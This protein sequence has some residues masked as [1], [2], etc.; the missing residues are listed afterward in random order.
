[1]NLAAHLSRIARS[2]PDAPAIGDGTDHLTY[3]ELDE[4]VTRLA[5][6]FHAAGLKRGD[7][8]AIAM[9]NRPEL[10]E[11]ILACFRAALVAVP[12]N[13]RLHASEIEYIVAHADARI[14][15]AGREHVSI[16]RETAA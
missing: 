16:A 12:I 2:S 3:G 11:V 14:I 8:V 4:R 13:S 6:A 5:A 1:M 10:I 9:V 15:V 7:R